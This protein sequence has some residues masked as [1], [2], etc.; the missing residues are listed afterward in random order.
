VR[1]SAGQNETDAVAVDEY[2][3]IGPSYEAI[4]SRRQQTAV[5]MTGRDRVSARL[6][7][8]YEFSE[9]H[10]ARGGGV[11]GQGETAAM[12]YEIPLQSG[13]H[14]EYSHLQH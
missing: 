13:E 9:T 14:A 3:R 6:S 2:S 8:R 4:D 1:A 11:A 10:V 12:D 7:E 5:A